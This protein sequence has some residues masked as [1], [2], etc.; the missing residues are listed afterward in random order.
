MAQRFAF[1]L[2][3]VLA[4]PTVAAAANRYLVEAQQAYANLEY[5]KVLPLLKRA[6]RSPSTAEERR[7]IFVLMAHIHAAYD[8]SAEATAAFVAALKE[9]PAYQPPAEAS[10]KIVELFTQAKTQLAGAP[11]VAVSAAPT[12]PAT[13]SATPAEP[14]AAQPE[15]TASGPIPATTPVTT[16]EAG[17]TPIWQRW[18]LWTAVGGV[19]LV[20]AGAI[21]W[22]VT[23]PAELP[24][25]DHGPYPMTP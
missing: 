19:V 1:I 12:P 6:E 5:D 25:H 23:R 2:A 3:L 20:S 17:A 9:D 13:M 11:P 24:A 4:S 21:A 18:W 8:R 15:P 7:D 14:V 22:A 10:P 16:A